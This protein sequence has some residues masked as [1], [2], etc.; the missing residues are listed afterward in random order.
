MEALR[1]TIEKGIEGTDFFIDTKN[2]DPFGTSFVICNKHS[3]N[4]LSV[5]HYR[6]E[7]SALHVRVTEFPSILPKMNGDYIKKESFIE[8]KTAKEIL[9]WLKTNAFYEYYI[10]KN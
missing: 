2:P 9:E 8:A 5:A 1:K 3:S 7:T 10:F 6:G 4:C